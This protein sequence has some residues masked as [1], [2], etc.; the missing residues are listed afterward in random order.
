MIYILCDTIAEYHIKY[1]NIYFDTNVIYN[2]MEANKMYNLL[3]SI[4]D[5]T[6]GH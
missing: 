2:I 4:Q 6:K 1:E 5:F 3:D